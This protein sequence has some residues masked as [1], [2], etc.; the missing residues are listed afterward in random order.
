MVIDKN[1]ALS[2][3]LELLRQSKWHR[4]Y[5]VE[6]IFRYII[7]PIKYNKLRLY[8]E[9]EKP[10]G[11]IT[12]CWLDKEEAEKFLISKYHISEE[13]YTQDIKEELWGIEFLSPYG[14][15]SK[16]MSLWRKEQKATYPDRNARVNWRRLSDP[17]KRHTKKV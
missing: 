8:Y 16:I 4:D 13:D 1:K 17:T 12:W 10:I 2:D 6:D 15:A 11:L 14:H 5:M 7:A 3:S 9:N